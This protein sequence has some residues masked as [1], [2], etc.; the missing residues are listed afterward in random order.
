MEEPNKIHD[1][2]QATMAAFLE[3][4]RPPENIRDQVDSGYSHIGQT[5]ELFEIRPSW[6]D[7][8]KIMHLPFA[9]INFVKSRQTWKLYWRRAKGNWDAYKPF[10]GAANLQD[11]LDCIVEDAH[12]CFHG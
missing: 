12:G 3:K 6:V 4:T 9:K 10:P 1:E 7:P 8:E 11:C 2:A 5:I